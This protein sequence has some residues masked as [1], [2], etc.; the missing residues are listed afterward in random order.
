MAQRKWDHKME[1]VLAIREVIMFHWMINDRCIIPHDDADAWEDIIHSRT[2]QDWWDIVD[3]AEIMFQQYPEDVYQYR[4]LKSD[5]A[6]IK[7]RLMFGKDITRPKNYATRQYNTTAWRGLMA[8]KDFL[9]DLNDTPTP[10]LTDEQ[11][12]HKEAMET[13]TQFEKLFND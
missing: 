4:N 3:V 10:H 8:F 13:P 1:V 6:E 7:K 12:Q 2:S 5:I 11:R 9:N